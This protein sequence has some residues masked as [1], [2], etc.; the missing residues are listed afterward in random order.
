M[1]LP[2]HW[3]AGAWVALVFALGSAGEGFAD[4]RAAADD[5]TITV[6]AD[7]E[8]P[9]D[10]VNLIELPTQTAVPTGAGGSATAEQVQQ[11]A[12]GDGSD[13]GQSVADEA[14]AR[15]DIRAAVRE[16]AKQ[17]TR[18]ENKP[19]KGRQGPPGN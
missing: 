19:G 11:D 15:N 1:K 13:F 9:D 3:P 4:E 14:H 5:A 16:E 6:V 17:Q 8:M 18:D 7:G 2:T 12:A 10:V